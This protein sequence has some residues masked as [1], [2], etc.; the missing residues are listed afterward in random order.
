MTISS[1]IAKAMHLTNEAVTDYPF[2]Y[3]VFHATEVSVSVVN[4]ATSATVPLV[5]ASD[6]VVYGLNEDSGG[7]INLTPAGLLKAGTGKHLV[8]LRDMPFK[9]EIDYRPHDIFPAETHERALDIATMERQE[10]REKISRAVLAPPDQENAVGYGDFQVLHDE[11]VASAKEAAR[12][13][14]AAEDSAQRAEAAAGGAGGE[15]VLPASLAEVNAGE[16]GGKYVSPFTLKRRSPRFLDAD[17]LVGLETPDAAQEKADAA[18]TA[19]KEYFDEQGVPDASTTVKGKVMLAALNDTT[20]TTK[21]ATPA[22]VAAQVTNLAGL[23]NS[24]TL[25]SSG[26]WTP[27]RKGVYIFLLIGGGG[28]SGG[29]DNT[30]SPVATSGG[31]GAGG[32]N[33]FL[34]FIDSLDPITVKIGSGGECPSYASAGG[35]GGVTSIEVDGLFSGV[36]A[37]G[38]SGRSVS[39]YNSSGGGAG[40]MTTTDDTPGASGGDRVGGAGSGL[41]AGAGGTGTTTAT[42]GGNSLCSQGGKSGASGGAGGTVSAYPTPE[43]YGYGGDGVSARNTP[44]NPGKPGCIKIFW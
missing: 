21:A 14:E 7:E 11:T 8:I 37:G 18:L 31:G 9:Q 4:P 38:G 44:G 27:P 35:G 33:T 13:A 26:E 40:G 19:A 23:A 22:G 17:D 28:A 36:G 39:G 3:K 41:S 10:L 30:P 16:V 43:K 2:P 5:L 25:T 1:S 42:N 20:S 34:M 24:A 6:Y 29:H 15:P 12:Q 32:I